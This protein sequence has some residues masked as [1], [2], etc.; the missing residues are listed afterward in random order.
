M[1]PAIFE[2]LRRETTSQ[3]EAAATT[4]SSPLPPQTPTRAPTPIDASNGIGGI[5]GN[6]ETPSSSGTTTVLIIVI[7]CCASAIMSATLFYIFDRKKNAQFREAC[8]RDPYLTRKEFV[9]RRKL[10]VL[11]RLE[12]EE[13]QRSIMIRKSL[14]SRGPSRSNSCEDVFDLSAMQQQARDMPEPPRGR[15]QMS[16]HQEQ[17]HHGQQLSGEWAPSEGRSRSGSETSSSASSA[18]RAYAE[19]HTS[20]EAEA[21]AAG[22][23]LTPQ[24]SAPSPSRSVLDKETAPPP[25]HPMQ[26]ITRPLAAVPRPSG[27]SS[28]F[29]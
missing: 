26:E 15:Q 11:E 19:P 1:A 17:L 10:S 29:S 28:H 9:R 27:G 20:V 4:P 2:K 18:R 12:E 23:P 7:L 5:P 3:A 6:I 13:L 24:S 22:A 21:E 14:A 25:I 16:E 8:K